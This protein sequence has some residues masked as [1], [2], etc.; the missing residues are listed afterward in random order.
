MVKKYA[1]TYRAAAGTIH[2]SLQ[3][4]QERKLQYRTRCNPRH[5][6][7]AHVVKT[8]P[9]TPDLLVQVMKT[10]ASL[11]VERALPQTTHT[12]LCQMDTELPGR[13]AREVPKDQGARDAPSPDPHGQ[14][15]RKSQPLM[16]SKEYKSR[17]TRGQAFRV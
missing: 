4:S 3:E 13:G 6:P 15:R 2:Q 10:W 11:L 1:R 14:T 12:L 16:D 17:T 7:I 8:L 9:S 5:D